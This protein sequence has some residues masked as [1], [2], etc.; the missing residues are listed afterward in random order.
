MSSGS[1][2]QWTT[3]ASGYASSHS[4]SRMSLLTDFSQKRAVSTLCPARLSRKPWRAV[5]T[6]AA[7]E[8]NVNQAGYRGCA[9]RCAATA[10]CVARVARPASPIDDTSG[11]EE[12]ICSIRVDPARGMLQIT[13]G[14]GPSETALCKPRY[15]ARDIVITA[16]TSAV[17]PAGSQGASRAITEIKQEWTDLTKMLKD[18]WGGWIDYYN[19]HQPKASP[20]GNSWR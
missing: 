9:S 14:A 17:K 11:W 12:M 6:T 4:P 10:A 13:M 2:R 20:G 7:A 19:Q 16:T 15:C 18:N 8:G 1:R 3:L 5:A